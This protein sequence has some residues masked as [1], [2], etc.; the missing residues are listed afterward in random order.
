MKT[1]HILETHSEHTP[2][3]AYFASFQSGYIEAPLLIFF[4]GLDETGEALISLQMASFQQDFNVRSLVIPSEDLDD[5]NSLA[6]TAIALTQQELAK[7]PRHLP[8]YLCAESFGGC[9]ALKV[10]SAIPDLFDRVVLVNSASSLHRV[11]WL[12]L[13]VQLFPLLPQP[14]YDLSQIFSTVSFLA[15]PNRLSSQAYKALLDSTR[16]APKRTLQRRLALMREFSVNESQLRQVSCPVLLVGAEADR[17]LPSVDEAYRLA[18]IFPQSQVVRLPHAGHACL[19][20][21]GINLDEIMRSHRFI[22][23]LEVSA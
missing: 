11:P 6:A 8:I 13:G 22:P 15:S 2:T 3:D 21:D 1:P 19:V 23:P 9:L 14:L 17:I 7:M 12:N 18:K 5:W 20:E 10:L 16:S 4:P